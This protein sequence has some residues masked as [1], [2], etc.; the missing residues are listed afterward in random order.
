MQLELTFFAAGT[1]REALN[2]YLTDQCNGLAKAT[3]KEY[4]ERRDWLLN[5][6][7]EGTALDSI[8]IARLQGLVR[9]WGPSG[10]GLLQVTL[11]K[12][13][14]FLMAALH[15]AAARGLIDPVRVPD[16]KWL[17]L[18]NDGDHRRA[19]LTVAQFEKFRERISSKRHRLAADIFFW[20]GHHTADVRTFQR[21]HLD[22][23]HAWTDSEGH[24][25]ARGRYLRRNQKNPRCEPVWF[26][27]EEEFREI[28]I[29]AMSER[30]GV[31]DHYENALIV[32]KI[33]GL[34]KA[35][36]TAADEAKVPRVSPIDLRRSFATMLSSR[37]YPNE[38][39]R[40]AMG[41]EGDVTINVENT[42]AKV[43]VS[44][45][46]TLNR[47]YLRPSPEMITDAIRRR[48]PV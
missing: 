21:R 44:R 37:G 38:Y 3:V 1:L 39:I 14:R 5:V 43:A 6:L 36:S 48:G 42:V 16:M 40:Q 41:H 32:G 33:W 35:F 26:P 46:T 4:G 23:A 19:Y 8:T 12:R 24:P 28:I 45:P 11:Q 20:T 9:E 25:V 22:P 31:H 30:S 47:H 13:I 2:A 34:S 17:K 18:R 15:Y 29:E 10:N 7:G 27:M